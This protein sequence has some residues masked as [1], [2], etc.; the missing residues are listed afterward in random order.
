MPPRKSDWYRWLLSFRLRLMAR[1]M[2]RPGNALWLW[3]ALAGLVG[4]LATVAFREAI[5]LLQW[6]FTRHTG[7]LVA[8]ASALQPWQRVWIPALGGLLAGTVL[9]LARRM[10]GAR[11]APDYME[12]IAAGDGVIKPGQSLLR[13]VSSL[14]SIASG[15]SI[16][17]EGAM[18][19]LGAMAASVLGKS[20][21]FNVP[22]QRLLTACG[23]AAGIASAYNAPIAG[24]LFV[25]EIVLGSM[26]M[27]GLG[28]LLVASVSAS[29][30][31]HQVVGYHASYDMPAFAPIAGTDVLPY[32][33]LGALTGLVAPAFLWMLD[34][35][36]SLFARLPLPLA[37]RLALGGLIV[38]LV[39]MYEPQVWGNGYS[40][41]NSILGSPW[42]WQALLLVLAAKLLATSATVG[43][44]AVGGVFTPTLFVGATFGAL[45]AHA[46]NALVP[47]MA[48]PSACAAVAMGAMLA[49]TTHAPLMSILM[50]SEMT[51]SYQITLPLMLA[52]VSAYS[53]ARV[54]RRGS[55]YADS[56]RSQ[57][58]DAGVQAIRLTTVADLI[59]PDR[60]S[61]TPQ[62]SVAELAQVFA[63][64]RVQYLY[65]VNEQGGFVG[66][67]SLH[68]VARAMAQHAV[69]TLFASD[70]LLRE[71]PALTPD[72]DMSAALLVFARHHGE[73]LP[74]VRDEGGVRKLLG[75]ATK[76]DVMLLMGA[77]LT[78]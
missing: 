63:R 16:G 76:T 27:S 65:V 70:I 24:A 66:A 21:D 38:G 33:M 6:G 9:V 13:S 5:S 46:L 39:S 78:R 29:I 36:K 19:Q 55:V 73:R 30:V 50:I 20:V 34:A 49:A 17:R 69:P 56:L 53:V 15:A 28:P 32:L 75:S 71:F 44:G 10:P 58:T 68:D 77:S 25:S 51:M 11:S 31:I 35:A 64:H 18:V 14:L 1:V 23:A 54:F 40:V 62:T 52:C 61:V 12:A 60:P 47:G 4:A 48:L 67:V 42:V 43:S 3:A 74:V 22:R 72:M 2:P 26:A 37:L 59:K 45:Y 57:R 8:A 41:V 7:S